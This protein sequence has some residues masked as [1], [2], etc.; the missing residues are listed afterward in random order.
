MNSG[1][2]DAA[3]L[4]WKFAAMLQGWGGPRFSRV[5]DAERRPVA[6]ENR[7][8]SERHMGVRLRIKRTI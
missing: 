4:A 2:C 3:D 6:Y 8:A 7:D 5:I 1:I